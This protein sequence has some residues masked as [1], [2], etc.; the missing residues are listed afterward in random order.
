MKTKILYTAFLQILFFQ[1]SCTEPYEIETVNY[2]NVLVVESTITDELKPQIVKLSR[3][4]SL[5]DT[6]VLIENNAT[7]TVVSTNGDNFSFSQDNDTGFYISNQS[8]LARPN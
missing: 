5:E 3:T 8:F 7:V 2:E 4:S 1:M 6:S